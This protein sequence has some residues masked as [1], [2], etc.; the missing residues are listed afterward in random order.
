MVR[1]LCLSIVLVLELSD[2]G[3]SQIGSRPNVVIVSVFQG[4]K[5]GVRCWVSGLI[6]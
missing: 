1:S 3:I 4:G 2:G 6:T 5:V